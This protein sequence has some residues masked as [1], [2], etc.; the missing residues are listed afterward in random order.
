MANSPVAFTD[1]TIRDWTGISD[2][3]DL[4]WDQM[5]SG[6]QTPKQALDAIVAQFQ[7]DIDAKGP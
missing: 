7:P 5:K 3:L 6:A 2:A 1:P 4:A